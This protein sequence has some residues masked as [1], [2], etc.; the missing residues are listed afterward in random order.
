MM[1]VMSKFQ[2][3]LHQF[4]SLFFFNLN[5]IQLNMNPIVF[6]W[7]RIKFKLS[8]TL[9]NIFIQVKEVT[10]EVT[11]ICETHSHACT[12]EGSSIFF[13]LGSGG[14]DFWGFFSCSQCV[15]M[16]FSESPGCSPRCFQLCLRFIPYGLPKQIDDR[17]FNMPHNVYLWRKVVCLFCFVCTYEIHQTKINRSCVLGFIG[18]LLTRRGAWAW[19]H[20]IWTCSVEEVHELGFMAF[21]LAV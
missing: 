15:P 18:K 5:F 9:F 4:A 19:F 6:S 20:G 14:K 17:E 13:F 16:R 1:K 7:I 2:Y 3:F 8:S 21:G 12:Y 10:K 11:K